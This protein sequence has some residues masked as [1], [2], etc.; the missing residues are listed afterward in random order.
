MERLFTLT[1][2]STADMPIAYYADNDIDFTRLK[3]TIDGNT[4]S[5]GDPS[6]SG[7]IF[8]DL[9]RSGK[10]SVTTQVNIEEFKEFFEKALEKGKDVLHLCFSSGLSGTCNSALIAA[11]ELSEKYPDRKVVVVDS[12]CASMGQGLLLDYAV[13]LRDE[14]KSIDEVAK[15]LEDNKLKLVHYF[16]VDDLGHLQR[17]GRISK[18]TA[19]FGGLLNVKPI[20]HVDNNGKLV[21]VGKVRGRKQSLDELVKIMEKLQNGKQKKA[22]ISHGDAEKDALYVAE[23]MKSRLG[24]ETVITNCIGPVIGGHAGPGTM[25][26]FFMGV[27]R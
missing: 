7:K 3:F 2:D 16:T 6:M 18:L 5:D 19:V 9:V 27:H 24:V 8:Y 23:Q 22:F 17:G 4:Y 10:T 26:I 25:A 20:L 1:T 11:D 12:L 14:G 15:W 13:T 21:S